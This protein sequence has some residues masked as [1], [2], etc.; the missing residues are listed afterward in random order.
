VRRQLSQVAVVPGGLDAVEDPGVSPTP[1]QPIPNPSPFVVSAP[2]FAW[3]LWSIRECFGLRISSSIAM[4]EPEYASQ[5]HISRMISGGCARGRRRRQVE[6]RLVLDVVEFAPVF[7]L[8]VI[9][10][11]V[12]C[13]RPHGGPT[14]MS[15]P[16][17]RERIPRPGPTPASGGAEGERKI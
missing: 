12:V 11:D 3:R 17:E 5:R 4:G 8:E 13:V 10:D 16:A 14:N 6:L 1:Y 2:S 15:A 9:P 7:G